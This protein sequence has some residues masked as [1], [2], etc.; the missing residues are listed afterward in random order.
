VTAANDLLITV[1]DNGIGIDPK[2]HE[3]IFDIFYRDDGGKK[4][5][6]GTGVGLSI[7]KKI[8]EKHNGRISLRSSKGGGAE[9]FIELPL[10][11][12]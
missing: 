7:V 2:Y 11:S 1:K 3:K 9:F 6:E 4:N 8:V 10:L 12:A 5:L